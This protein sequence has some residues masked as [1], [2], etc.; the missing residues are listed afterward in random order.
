MGLNLNKPIGNKK[1]KK[2][3][4]QELMNIPIEEITEE[5]IIQRGL[6]SKAKSDTLCYLGIAFLFI[7]IILPPVFNKVFDYTRPPET[8]ADVV[9]AR[10]SCTKWSNKV[11]NGENG[12]LLTTAFEIKADYRD[13]NIQATTFKF[14][15]NKVEGTFDTSDIDDLL[16]LEDKK[17]VKIS[18]QDKKKDT[19]GKDGID[20]QHITTIEVD[21]EV[22]PAL[23]EEDALKNYV[24]TF[25]AEYNY[26]S[27]ENGGFSCTKETKTVYE[28][29]ANPQKREE[30]WNQEEK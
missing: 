12:K 28:D 10:F 24:L 1:S 23:K 25:M 9:Y 27:G 3:E 13:S 15:H 2:D 19:V 26:L 16:L 7:L 14:Y 17:G 29:T 21:Y 11:L 6:K 8:H 22:N 5:Q 4:L 30:I 18:E 20:T